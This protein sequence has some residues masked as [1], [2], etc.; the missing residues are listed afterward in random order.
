VNM[1][2]TGKQV[3]IVAPR[4][5]CTEYGSSSPFRSVKFFDTRAGD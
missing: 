5:V 1:P 2:L 4:T 3:E